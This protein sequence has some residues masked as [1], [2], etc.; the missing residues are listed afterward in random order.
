MKQ[1]LIHLHPTFADFA[2]SVIVV[3]KLYGISEFRYIEGPSL[4]SKMVVSEFAERLGA[5]SDSFEECGLSISVKKSRFGARVFVSAMRRIKLAELTQLVK[6]KDIGLRYAA[7][8]S[9]MRKPISYW[10]LLSPKPIRYLF[11]LLHY[12]RGILLISIYR[13]LLADN[14]PDI[15]V[16]SHSTYIPYVA[17]LK[18]ANSLAIEIVCHDVRRTSVIEDYR[19]FYHNNTELANAA[20][21]YNEFMDFAGKARELT[22]DKGSFYA[23]ASKESSRVED[24]GIKS[25]AL[26]ILPHCIKDANFTCEG[27]QML[28]DNYFDWIV[29]TVLVLAVR[30]SH[31]DRIVFKIHPHSRLFQDYGLLCLLGLALRFGRN[32]RKVIVGERIDTSTILK[33]NKVIPVTCHGSVAYENGSLGICTLAVGKAPAPTKCIVRPK[34]IKEYKN[35]LLYPGI[36]ENRMEIDST[37]IALA[38]AQTQVLSIM[39]MP[40][41]VN[42]E[43]NSYFKDVFY[44]G[45]IGSNKK[46]V[47]KK[48]LTE[49]LRRFYDSFDVRKIRVSQSMSFIAYKI[50]ARNHQ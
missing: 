22:V 3:N 24:N 19:D 42:K 37:A 28:Y 2:Q 30:E 16:S 41:E 14:R 18:A 34:D 9:I 8:D 17:L 23:K 12:V 13:E 11:E 44:F 5:I 46:P 38:K 32:R 7:R 50:N 21:K 27:K 20:L 26:V 35:M 49:V 25:R 33:G 43:Y 1:C 48:T 45:I 15:V 6:M 10:Y 39:E 31:Y 4:Q 36:F 47:D 29:S 40:P